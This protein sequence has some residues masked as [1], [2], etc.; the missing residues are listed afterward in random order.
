MSSRPSVRVSQRGRVQPFYVMEVLK[1]ANRRAVEH[2]DLISL[3]AG[4]PSTPAPRPVRQAAERALSRSQVMGY[5][6]TIGNRDLREAIATHYDE[7]Y[8]VAVE[9]DEVVVTTGSSGAFTAL[10]LAAFDAGDTVL[11]TRPGYPA[12]RNTLTALGCD[13]VEIDCDESTRFQLGV[14]H[15]EA[16]ASAHGA[17]AG[18]IVASPANP[19]G[20]IIPA[21]DLSRLASW[22]ESNGTLLISD[23]IYHGITYGR[24]AACAW[25]TSRS[26]AVVGSF[27]KYYSMTGWRIGWCLVPQELRRPVELLLGN[28]NICA[29]AVSQ[30]AAVEAFSPESVAELETHV[31]RYAANRELVQRRIGELGVQRIAPPDGAFYAYADISHLTDDSLQWAEEVLAATGVAVTPGVDFAPVSARHDRHSDGRRFMRMSL[32][33]ATDEFDTA[34][35]RLAEYVHKCRTHA[36]DGVSRPI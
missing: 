2:G 6:D 4:Q 20:S 26:A 23:E 29:P 19:T 7:A 35:T 28:L 22:C 15:L 12:Y 18:V 14:G 21:D 31:R 10:F 11:M 33:G 9:P 25:E 3:C 27:S 30:V 36:C 32:A 17:P 1:A 13:V 24:R 8:G 5:T 16:H 34:M